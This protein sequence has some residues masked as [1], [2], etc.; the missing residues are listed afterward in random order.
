LD[1]DTCRGHGADESGYDVQWMASAIDRHVYDPYAL[2][3]EAA[4]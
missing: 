2:Y 3:E 1:R 4:A